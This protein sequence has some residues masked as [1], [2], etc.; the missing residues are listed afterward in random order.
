MSG[1]AYSQKPGPAVEP[2]TGRCQQSEDW[3]SSKAQWQ[4]S[5]LVKQA[6]VH[7]MRCE[8]HGSFSEE[9]LELTHSSHPAEPSQ[10]ALL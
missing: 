7:L 8:R 5:P 9:R 3:L 6:S 1:V 4:H 2:R 10:Q